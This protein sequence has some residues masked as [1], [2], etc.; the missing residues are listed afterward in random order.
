MD[1]TDEMLDLLFYVLRGKTIK[2]S[3]KTQSKAS[4]AS[5]SS[6]DSK[7]PFPQFPIAIFTQKC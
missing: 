5:A 3:A 2:S 7:L 4:S 1:K 6:P